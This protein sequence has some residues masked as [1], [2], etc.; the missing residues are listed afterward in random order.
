MHRP[1]VTTSVNKWAQC[2]FSGGTKRHTIEAVPVDAGRRYVAVVPEL[3]EVECYR[4]LAERALDRPI[5]GVRVPDRHS[6]AAG[7]SPSRLGRALAGRRLAAARR[8]GKLLL[9]D[10]DS[11]APR[12]LG[13][14]F[15]MTGGLTVDG[16]LAIDKLLY[17]SGSYG[18][19]WVRFRVLFADGGELALHD[20]RRLGRVEL[21]PD[22]HRLG[23]DAWSITLAELAAALASRGVRTP[24]PIK[25]RLLDQSHLAGLGNLLV[26]EL[27]WRA[28]LRPTRPVGS[29]E[30]RELRRLHR[31]LRSMLP[32]MLERGG[33]HTGEL[34]AERRRGGHCPRDGAPLVR[35]R[36][37]GRTTYWCP[38]HQK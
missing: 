33:S 14:R 28:G 12:T 30:E 3:L 35:A 21:D 6:L 22:E 20:P 5:A 2:G 11:A 23:P 36:V 16:K 34:M 27:L 31:H 37:G 38:V 10:L 13:L 4:R 32:E 24:A 7:E 25:A 19:Q 9:L 1:E 15:G 29:L 26:D 8:R 17:S 18:P